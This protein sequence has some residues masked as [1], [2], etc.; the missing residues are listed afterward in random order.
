MQTLHKRRLL[1]LA[2]F[3]DKLSPK[4]FDLNIFSNDCG[5]VCCAIGWCPAVFP[6]YW[7]RDAF[8]EPFLKG[9][10]QYGFYKLGSFESAESFFGLNAAE[11]E[12][13]F[14]VSGEQ[15]SNI[16]YPKPKDVA[17]AI[18]T[19]IQEKENGQRQSK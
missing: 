13:L 5:S 4:K 18:R 6:T 1:K 19:F 7:T 12:D 3:L 2:R 17:K 11:S 10:N 8:S 15:Y 9:K 14:T 16:D